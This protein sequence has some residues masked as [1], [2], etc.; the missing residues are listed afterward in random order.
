MRPVASTVLLLLPLMLA[1]CCSAGKNQTGRVLPH[2]QALNASLTLPVV[3]AYLSAVCKYYYPPVRCPK[4]G[5]EDWTRLGQDR[6]AKAFSTP[7]VNF[8]VAEVTHITLQ[9]TATFK[10][11]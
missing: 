9:H 3:A 5:M 1:S 6:C 2:A 4:D 11:L 10:E 8:T 7:R